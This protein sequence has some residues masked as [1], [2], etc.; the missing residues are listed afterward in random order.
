[1]GPRCK[2]VQMCIMQLLPVNSWILWEGHRLLQKRLQAQVVLLDAT[3]SLCGVL[4][5][6]PSYSI[7]EF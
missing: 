4:Y 1:M 2:T 5:P 3:K 6:V 7:V